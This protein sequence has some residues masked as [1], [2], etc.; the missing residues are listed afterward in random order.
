MRENIIFFFADQQR[1]D[2][3]TPEI[4]PN[5][6]KC[7]EDGAVF[8]NT[9]TCQ[10]VCGPARACLQTGVYA[11]EN[12]S[13][14]NAIPLNR[15]YKTLAEYLKESGYDTAYIGKW[16]LASGMGPTAP[17]YEKS[18]VP[19]EL[20]GGYDYWMASD[21]LEFTS[22]GYGGYVFDTDMNKIEFDG[23]RA[24]KITDF[25]IDYIKEKS[26][27][28]KPFFMFLSHIEPHHQ[29][30]TDNFECAPEDKGKFDNVAIPE[31]LTFPKKGNAARKY[32][33]YLACIN[34][35]DK[36]LMRPVDA[37]KEKGIFD[38]TVI[39]YTADHGCHFRTRNIE[40]KRSCHDASI[41][42]PLVV[43]G[44][45]YRGGKAYN[46]IVSLID[47]PT[48]IL[49]IAGVEKPDYMRGNDI[50]EI[51]DG[52]GS[53]KEAYVEISESQTGR[54]I[55]TAEYTYSARSRF[56]SYFAK[57]AKTYVEDYL[58]DNRVDGAQRNN[59]IKDKDYQEVRKELRERLKK[60]IKEVEG[61]D[62]KILP[63]K[64]IKRKI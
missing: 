50:A 40:Y 2:T 22:D 32:G 21:V 25:A 27:D 45:A 53:R 34:R 49:A 4:M 55:R 48:S 8:E 62:V 15:D 35:L 10:P 56:F 1:Y 28:K 57:G 7:A 6:T 31:D 46:D 33:D 39:F 14:I 61:I 12:G 19:K 11:T 5:L 59:L 41:H 44:G 60:H 17:H 54:A 3:F 63:R 43:F 30:S 18:A 47:I 42:V 64:F 13:Y 58:Y 38:N 26:S 51:M 29:N 37:L 20:R 24:D 52:K 36:N 16:H 9:F 23:V